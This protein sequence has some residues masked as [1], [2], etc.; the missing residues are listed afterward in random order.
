[1]LIGHGAAWRGE[2]GQGK[3]WQ[4][5]ARQGL[6]RQGTARHGVFIMHSNG[7]TP[8]ECLKNLGWARH[9]LAWHGEAWQGMARQ[10]VVFHCLGVKTQ[11]IFTRQGLA[12][13]GTARQG[14]ARRGFKFLHDFY[15]NKL[16]YSQF[17]LLIDNQVFLLPL[18]QHNY[19]KTAAKYHHS[20]LLAGFP[21]TLLCD[22]N[23]NDSNALILV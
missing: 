23:S 22:H 15:N 1:M 3:A 4:G 21:K 16:A 20:T 7:L 12:G 9:G 18:K 13:L 2:A 14:E 8:K 6:A 19:Y 11:T 17:C 10:G 5:L